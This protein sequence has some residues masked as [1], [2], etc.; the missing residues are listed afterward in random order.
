M[1]GAMKQPDIETLGGRTL[2]IAAQAA[3]GYLETHNLTA[4]P[5]ALASCLASWVRA[6][7]PEAL[8]DA[9]AAIDAGLSEYAELTYKATIM[10]AGIEAAKEATSPTCQQRRKETSHGRPN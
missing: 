4:T 1:S 2:Q 8:R 3:M 5:D 7:L 9:K 6:K 10:L